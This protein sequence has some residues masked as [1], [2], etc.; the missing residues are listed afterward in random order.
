MKK[1]IF[2]SLKLKNF[3]SVGNEPVVI[4]F[5]KG[6]NIITG[7][8]KDLMDRQNGTGK[9]TIIDAFHFSLFGETTRDLKKEFVCNNITNETSEVS[10]T[11]SI[12]DDEYEIY[13]T[14]KPSKCFLF[15]NGEDISRDSISNT[16]EYVLSLLKITPEIFSNCI[17]LSINST[18]PFMAQKKIEKRKFIENVF[19][20]N[21]FSEMNSFL[22]EDYSDIKKQ[23]EYNRETYN[24]SENNLKI[25]LQKN[26][27]ITDERINRILNCED[28][29]KEYSEEIL[30]LKE[31]ISNY[32]PS[33]NKN[34]EVKIQKLEEKEVE[35][36]TSKENLIQEV[37][38]LK[39]TMEIGRAHV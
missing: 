20:L 19:N 2:K 6:L 29:V 27:R 32:N 13:R 5:Q 21:V 25:L 35:K 7:I 22:K 24:Q 34:N 38:R 26:K 28:T 12:G 3:F 10:L 11:F 4:N 31:Y 18:I 15:H 16:T 1:I 8:N 9:S 39:T 23:L 17:C 14:L 33:D 37:S 30:K 36:N